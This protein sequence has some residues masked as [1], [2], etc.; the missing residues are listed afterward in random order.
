MIPVGFFIERLVVSGSGKPDAVLDFIDGLN[1]VAGA[2]DTGK[3][4]AVSCLDYAFGASKAPRSIAAARG[5][6]T[7]ILTV[8]ERAGG[9]RFE[10]ERSLAGGAKS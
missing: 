5:Y 6:D 1:V 8:T 2:S 9:H 10:I 4:Y 7:I 3:S